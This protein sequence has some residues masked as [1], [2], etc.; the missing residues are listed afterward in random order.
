MET[1]SVTTK[2]QR[3]PAV[4][5]LAYNRVDE[6]MQ[7]LQ[8]VVQQDPASIYVSVDGPK[9]DS[10]Q[11][12]EKV[13]AVRQAVQ[14]FQVSHSIT[15]RFAK[16]N[17][18]VLDGVLDGIDWFFSQE[19]HG[20]VLE[21]DVVV[22]PDSL[23][24]AS[25]LLGQLKPHSKIGSI[26]LFSPVPRSKLTHPHNPVR[27]GALPSSQYWGTWSDRWEVTHQFRYYSPATQSQVLRAVETVPDTRLRKFWINH[28]A[29]NAGGWQC[30]ED[31][32]ILTHW[33]SQWSAAYTH[34]NFSRHIGF[35]SAATNSWD[36]PSWYPTQYD[37]A[38]A[39]PIS[40]QLPEPDPRA[41]R[42]YFNQRFGLSPW[43]GIKRAIWSRAPWLR[44]SYLS[45]RQTVESKS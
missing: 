27:L 23:P 31:L 18:G 2:Q 5:I 15:P 30:W 20:I 43:K 34:G 29:S 25:S 28:L 4:L 22:A 7:T 11:D 1:K 9:L 24:L 39:I 42:W 3:G 26:S 13:S 37:D 38:Q 12:Q 16:T 35:T 19:A 32:W 17:G 36:Q 14:S 6:F 45:V 8:A 40:H 44:K 33:I 21:D 10:K 41:D